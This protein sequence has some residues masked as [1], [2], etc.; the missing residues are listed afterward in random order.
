[1]IIKKCQKKIF[2][3]DFFFNYSNLAKYH[4]TSEVQNLKQ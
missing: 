1:M 3:K 2:P 4:K